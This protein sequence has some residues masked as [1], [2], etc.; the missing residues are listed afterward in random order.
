M[1]KKY[2]KMLENN[3]ARFG[4]LSDAQVLALTMFAEARG[5]IYDGQVAVGSAILERVDHRGW[6]GKTI[7]EVCFWP[8]QFSCYLA[9]DKNLPIMLEIAKDWAA[10]EKKYKGLRDILAIAEGLLSGLVP[11]DPD[12]VR[13]HCCQYLAPWAK[14]GVDWWEKMDFVKKVGGHEFYADKDIG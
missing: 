10:G 13:T 4:H 2:L 12:I 7:K 6:D 9:G 11:R 14:E 3:F 5:E 1:K 8:F